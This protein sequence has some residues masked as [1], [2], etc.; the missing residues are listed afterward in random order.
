MRALFS[1]TQGS[2]ILKI[3]STGTATYTI[4]SD[5]VI[6]GI[7]VIGENKNNKYNRVIGTFVNPD[8]ELATRYYKLSTSR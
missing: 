3:E 5:N 6:G 2:Y 8:K 4:T 1:Y 7:K